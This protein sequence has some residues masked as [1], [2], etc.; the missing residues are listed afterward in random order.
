M[1]V[2]EVLVVCAQHNDVEDV[3]SE[4]LV[5]KGLAENGLLRRNVPLLRAQKEDLGAADQRCRRSRFQK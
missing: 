1:A 5:H 3:R 4:A 2:T